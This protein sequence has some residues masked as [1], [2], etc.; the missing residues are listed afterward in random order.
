MPN[1]EMIKVEGVSD[2]VPK[3]WGGQLAIYFCNY[4]EKAPIVEEGQVA[5]SVGHD[6][7]VSRAGEKLRAFGSE[8]VA[9]SKAALFLDEVELKAIKRSIGNSNPN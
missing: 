6:V 7:C 3:L 1:Q 5:V 2:L 4:C 9:N 8:L